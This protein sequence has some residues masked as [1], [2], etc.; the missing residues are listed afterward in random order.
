MAQHLPKAAKGEL[1]K[2]LA[3]CGSCRIKMEA[4][5]DAGLDVTAEWDRMERA[6]Q[7]AETL[8]RLEQETGGR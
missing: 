1:Q 6:Q 8:L 4:L 3:H 5:R 2:G 7:V